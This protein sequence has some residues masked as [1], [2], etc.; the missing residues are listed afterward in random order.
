ME[1]SMT[2]TI[3]EKAEIMAGRLNR[4]A[5]AAQVRG[6][7]SAPRNFYPCAKALEVGEVLRKPGAHLGVQVMRAALTSCD[8]HPGMTEQ[9]IWDI[10]KNA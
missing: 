2:T 6:R 7:K 5:Y 9:D 10:L 8:C 4:D 3:F 1:K